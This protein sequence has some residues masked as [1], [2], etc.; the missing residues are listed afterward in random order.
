MRALI[1]Y[2]TLLAI[3]SLSSM[4]YSAPYETHYKTKQQP[5][6]ERQAGLFNS[7]NLSFYRLTRTYREKYKHHEYDYSN[8]NYSNRDYYFRERNY[9]DYSSTPKPQQYSQPQVST[10]AIEPPNQIE[11]TGNTTFIFN[12]NDLNWGAYDEN[13]TLV[14]YG[15]ASGGKQ[16]CPDIGRRCKTP[17]G[18]FSVYRKGSG[19][20]RSSIY[21][22]GKGG[23]LMQYCMF[24]RGGY[25]I[26]GSD[27]VPNR[28]ASHG[29]IR[30][31][32]SAAKWLNEQFMR[33]GTKV[34]IHAY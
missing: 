8:R 24:F 14:N 18:S 7:F 32:P 3:F 13:G 2:L 30:V 34:I 10:A 16:Y 15:R 28:N 20:C 26:H 4:A 27:D 23:A 1:K 6:K 25:A 11:A 9:P 29:C 31:L 33:I 17:I 22:V 5:T 21:P 12:P 19:D